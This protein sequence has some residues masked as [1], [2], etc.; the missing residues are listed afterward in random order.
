M[1]IHWRVR[2]GMLGGYL[3]WACVNIGCSCKTNDLEP[4]FGGKCVLG[5]L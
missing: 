3:L 2:F 4:H 5:S 1:A